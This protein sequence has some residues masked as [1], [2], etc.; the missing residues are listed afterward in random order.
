MS[1][2]PL[3]VPWAEGLVPRIAAQ[4]VG[5]LEAWAVA[6]AAAVLGAAQVSAE[7]LAEEPVAAMA[8]AEDP[9]AVVLAAS[10]VEASVLEPVVATAASEAMLVVMLA[11]ATLELGAVPV[12]VASQVVRLVVART[13]GAVLASGL[14]GATASPA[15]PV[16]APA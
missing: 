14:V 8:V 11:V 13:S 4:A 2:E 16:E 10:E 6:L 7:V 9:L 1:V 3:E 5:P 15:V 12:W